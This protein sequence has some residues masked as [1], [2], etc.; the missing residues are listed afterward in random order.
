MKEIRLLQSQAE[1]GQ[2]DREILKKNEIK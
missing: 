1:E 2:R